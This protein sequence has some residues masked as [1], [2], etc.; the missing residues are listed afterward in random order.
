MLDLM[1][2]SAA[3]RRA[4]SGLVSASVP[5]GAG[6]PVCDG[7][8][9]GSSDGSMAHV[10]GADSVASTTRLSRDPLP[11][12]F[13]HAASR[14][15]PSAPNSA[16]SGSRVSGTTQPRRRGWYCFRRW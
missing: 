10:T 8:R 7:S 5:E 4:A 1:R 14:P 9:L 16:G 6:C 12:A 2:S 15:S 3:D 13:S 11:R